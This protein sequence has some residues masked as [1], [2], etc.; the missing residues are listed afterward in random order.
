MSEVSSAPSKTERKERKGR[1][2]IRKMS[3]SR[4]EY[5]I[6]LK[7]FGCSDYIVKL[8][9]NVIGLVYRSYEE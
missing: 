9:I 5:L 8:G 1:I 2:S 4:I 7:L 6:P 3:C